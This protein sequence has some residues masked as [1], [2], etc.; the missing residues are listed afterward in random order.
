MTDLDLQARDLLRRFPLIDGHNDL[1]WELRE[2]AE[3][4]QLDGGVSTLSLAPGDPAAVN[5]AEPVTGTHTDLPG[6]RP[7]ASAPVL[8]GL[9]PAEL[10]RAT[11][12]SPPPSSRST[13]STGWSRATR[14]AGAG[15]DRGRVR[16]DHGLGAGR[17][18]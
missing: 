18:A 7:A 4:G 5:L 6:S 12:R 10:A 9:R 15:A 16:A 14:T 3:Q 8:V 13:W 11:R 2:R 17:L 1:P